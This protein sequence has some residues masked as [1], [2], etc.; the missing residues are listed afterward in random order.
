[1]KC[2]L[3]FV[4]PLVTKALLCAMF[5]AYMQPQTLLEGFHGMLPLLLH[6]RHDVFSAPLSF[7]G[8][9]SGMSAI[10]HSLHILRTRFSIHMCMQARMHAASVCMD[11]PVVQPCLVSCVLV[12][13][14]LRF[15][16][17]E[18]FVDFCSWYSLKG[19]LVCHAPCIHAVPNNP[20]GR[21]FSWHA[22]HGFQFICAGTNACCFCIHGRACVSAP[23][24]CYHAIFFCIS[25]CMP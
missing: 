9:W 23:C 21:G 10:L 17:H 24:S 6:S 22:Q 15:G 2:L 5:H 4:Q 16:L 18:V 3:I 8:I 11:V 12:V 7:H 25:G 19:F 20:R 1:M 13:F 14:C